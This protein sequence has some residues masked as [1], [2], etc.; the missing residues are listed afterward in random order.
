[1]THPTQPESKETEARIQE[2]IQAMKI[3]S[4]LTLRKATRDFSVPHS[5]L[6]DQ[7]YGKK[8]RNQAYKDC[9]NLIYNKEL[10]LVHW[11]TS[12][13]IHGYAPRYRTICE[14]AEIIR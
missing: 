10:E 13:I 2:A 3:D 12:C 5:M 11:I 6:K 9:M 8:P 7:F 4:K 14:L 1:M